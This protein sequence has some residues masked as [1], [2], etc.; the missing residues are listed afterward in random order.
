MD[1][2][3]DLEAERLAKWMAEKYPHLEPDS[4]EWATVSSLHYLRREVPSVEPLWDHERGLFVASLGNIHERY[5][6]A[7][8]EIKALYS[9]LDNQQEEIVYRMSFVHAVTVMESY[10]LYCARALLEHDWPLRRFRDEYYLP[11]ARDDKK[12]KQTVPNMELSLFRDVAILYVS[13]RMTFHNVETI[14]RFRAVLHQPPVWPIAP[15]TMITQWRND[16]VHRNGVGKDYV[17]L[18]ISPPILD[19]AL[20]CIS[21]LIDASH[22]SIKQEV[23]WFGNGRTEE[24]RVI[25]ASALGISTNR[26]LSI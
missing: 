7:N 8:R 15:L 3:I 23:D 25:I 13:S 20:Q 21:A 16:L 6:H 18:D 5:V 4:D 9:L 10:L 24:N 1:D 17:P 22:I 11:F 26:D 2:W 12:I 14:E 19:N